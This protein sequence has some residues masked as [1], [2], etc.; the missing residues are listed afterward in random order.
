MARNTSV[1]LE[2]ET[3]EKVPRGARRKRETRT[4]LL[5][6]ALPL[7][8]E[9]GMEGVTINEITESADVGF[10]S[11]YNHFE[12]KEAI[13][14]AL[15][16]WV[17]EEFG[18]RLDRLVEQLTD[19][20][21]RIAVCV[22]HTLRRAQSEQLWARFLI[23]E[24]LSLGATSRG[25]GQRLLRDIQKGMA[26][27][28]FAVEDSFTVV[29]A[30]GAVLAAISIQLASANATSKDAENFAKQGISLENLPE[31]TAAILLQ[32]LGIDQ[33]EAKEI[34]HRALPEVET[35]NNAG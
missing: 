35:Q 9:R 25:L 30:G 29:A 27:K 2:S 21:E 6:A 11:F 23:R 31:R 19:P 32:M 7:M 26:A 20:A 17:F 14:S 15:I 16:D 1:T 4:R 13:Y 18:E 24:G 28:R 5:E 10:G 34:A 33:L 12:S 3:S 8:A 22:R